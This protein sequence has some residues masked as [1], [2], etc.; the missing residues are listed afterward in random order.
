MR[1][2]L[3]VNESGS[4]SDAI[5]TDEAV[6][7]TKA[8]RLVNLG[9]EDRPAKR[10]KLLPDSIENQDFNALTFGKLVVSLNGS[11]QES[12]VINLSNLHNIIQ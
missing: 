5:L 3:C 4:F 10:R 1:K 12:P 8:F 2:E 9:D 11:T 7:I 6:A